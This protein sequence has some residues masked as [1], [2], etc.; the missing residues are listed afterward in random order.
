MCGLKGHFWKVSTEK[1]QCRIERIILMWLGLVSK[2]IV[3]VSTLLK[4]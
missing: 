3:N 2:K 4:C 1:D